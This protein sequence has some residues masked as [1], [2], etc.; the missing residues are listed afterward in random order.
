MAELK[1][2]E[3]AVP[4]YWYLISSGFRTYLYLPL[5]FKEFYPRHDRGGACFEKDLSELLGRMKFPEEYH[6]GI[7]RVSRPRECLR[8][9]LAVPPP[10]RLRNPHVRFF[11]ERNPGYLRGD[12]LVCLAEFSL[13]N[14]LRTARQALLE[15]AL[16][17]C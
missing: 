15:A 1:M 10:A 14:A 7:V 13:E 12:E 2:R 17:P 11:L 4:L 3:P 6:D 9:E 8:R 5:F 16:V